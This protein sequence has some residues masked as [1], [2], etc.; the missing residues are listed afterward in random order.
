MACWAACGS[1]IAALDHLILHKEALEAHLSPA[2]FAI[3][4][5]P[6]GCAAGFRLGVAYNDAFDD[7]AAISEGAYLLRS[8]ICDWSDQELRKA[9][10]QLTQAEAAFRIQD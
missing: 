1:A 7:W 4:L 10:I 8:N 9:N 2:R 3:T 5:E 6:D